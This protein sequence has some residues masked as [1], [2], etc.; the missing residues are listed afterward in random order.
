MLELIPFNKAFLLPPVELGDFIMPIQRHTKHPCGI[1]A[2]RV[3]FPMI[4][5]TFRPFLALQI[6]WVMV[7][8]GQ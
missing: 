5:Y 6:S 2:A 4:F 7:P 3:L 8:M 1:T